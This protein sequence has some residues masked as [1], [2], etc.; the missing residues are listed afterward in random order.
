MFHWTGRLTLFWRLMAGYLIIFILV[1]MVGFYAIVQLKRFNTV[2]RHILNVDNRLLE[3]DKKLSDLILS[4]HRFLKKYI[5]TKDRNLYQQF[6]VSKETIDRDL[7]QAMTF[8]DSPALK[9]GFKRIRFN[10]D[11]YLSLVEEEMGY[12]KT[13]QTYSTKWYD[14]EKGKLVD[15][16]LRE[17]DTLEIQIQKG[18][19]QR[20]QI[21]GEAGESAR[22][23]A[24]FL[25]LIALFSII[26]ISWLITRSITNPLRL[27]R[28]KT[29]EISEGRFDH[30][31]TLSFSPEIS[32][33]AQAFNVMSHKLMTL[34][35]MKA[36]FFSTMSHEL[37]TPL[38]SIK[39]GTA[40]LEEEAA[41]PIT[42]KQKKLLSII[43]QESQRLIELV[44]SSLDLSKMETGM[45]TYHFDQGDL[46]PLIGK[47]TTEITPLLEAKKI[48]IETAIKETLPWIRM[49]HERI[50]QVLRN[51]VGNAVKFT[52]GDGRV[53][54][55]AQS[56]DWGIRVAV[57]DTGPG[58]PE[59]H[60]LTIF[61]K[62]HQ[63]VPAKSYR[64]KG[65]GLGLAIVKHIIQSHGGRVWA[66]STLGEGS[67]FYFW[68]PA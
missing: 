57:R 30:D 48:A 64:I 54:I 6:L 28:L 11:L 33:L 12:I 13:K 27:L 26:V 1:L 5:I 20:M 53:E 37:R 45:M 31:L 44:T 8:A 58:I 25:S 32:E 40:L 52:P 29:R 55:S 21:Q 23:V 3:Y 34:D 15:M 16:I 61:N 46:V 62:F 19:Q 41:G 17:F 24:A 56:I 67:V 35:K 18:I 9:E 4:Q 14:Q 36:D 49:D 63:V 51:L 38:T 10:Q 66:E 50:L 47:V 42:K 7:G 39:E 43:A 2:T 65:T 59:E 22:I 60:L 68:L